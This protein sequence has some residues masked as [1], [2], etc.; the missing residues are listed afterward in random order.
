[1]PSG[2]LLGA[3]Y[4]GQEAVT[5]FV[6]QP[7]YAFARC[8]PL[9]GRSREGRSQADD[10]SN[11]VRPGATLAFLRAS[12]HQRL[13]LD[14]GTQGQGANALGAAELVG[15]DTDHIDRRSQLGD[16]EPGCGLDRVR[17]EHGAGGS[18][19]DEASHFGQ[20]LEGTDLVVDELD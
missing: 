11:V 7:P 4:P 8:R 14:R 9:S 13:E 3:G 12:V 15:A 10:P 16:V 18:P 6:P 1:L 17:V 20:G 5:K 2:R 19:S